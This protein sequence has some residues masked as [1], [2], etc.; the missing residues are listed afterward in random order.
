MSFLSPPFS[1]SRTKTTVI[2]LLLL[3]T[4]LFS[5]LQLSQSEKIA[6]GSG[7][8][9]PKPGSRIGIHFKARNEPLIMETKIPII[10]AGLTPPQTFFLLT[11][12]GLSKACYLDDNTPIGVIT[13]VDASTI[14]ITMTTTLLP[15]NP[16][17]IQVPRDGESAPD[18]VTVFD[19]DQF[20]CYFRID[21]ATTVST[22][23]VLLPYNVVINAPEI[24]D[25]NLYF[26]ALGWKT[27]P[28]TPLF[29]GSPQLD[30][31]YFE[32][33]YTAAIEQ[34]IMIPISLFLI[35]YPTNVPLTAE[36]M[37][38]LYEISKIATS[39]TCGDNVRL[40]YYPPADPTT[41]LGQ[42]YVLTENPT[43]GGTCKLFLP[44]HI[45]TYYAY[46]IGVRIA[47]RSQPPPP[48]FNLTLFI[49]QPQ[50]VMLTTHINTPY[51]IPFGLA[52]IT[53]PMP[54]DLAVLDS[55]PLTTSKPVLPHFVTN[56]WQ[57]QPA[58]GLSK[59]G[60]GMGVYA[61]CPITEPMMSITATSGLPVSDLLRGLSGVYAEFDKLDI[62][63]SVGA[64]EQSG[65]EESATPLHV[66]EEK[67]EFTQSR[68][69]LGSEDSIDVLR[70]HSND[71]DDVDEKTA[72]KHNQHQMHRE[73]HLL[74][75]ATQGTS[76]E[77]P[78]IPTDH[79]LTR[80]PFASSMGNLPGGVLAAS[81]QQFNVQQN[82]QHQQNQQKNQ[83]G[84][85]NQQNQQLFNT[86]DILNFNNV[87][88][89]TIPH[90]QS[91]LQHQQQQQQQQQQSKQQQPST[92]PQIT[93]NTSPPPQNDEQ[94]TIISTLSTPV[95]TTESIFTPLQGGF[96][97]ALLRLIVFSANIRNVFLSYITQPT[98]VTL[99]LLAPVANFTTPTT[100]EYRL[101]DRA[102]TIAIQPAVLLCWVLDQH[103]LQRQPH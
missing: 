78:I 82:Q 102:G 42:F 85:Q 99:N 39:P 14:V 49:T 50:S 40:V 41:G 83:Q 48:T 60:I 96:N 21:P 44:Q 2:V 72:F 19:T 34:N 5:T 58:S 13:E 79:Q 46:T 94:P 28:I 59:A 66:Q 70:F 35:T 51:P 95:T 17:V 20:T 25:F 68:F 30:N 27:D 65:D 52:Q 36:M 77:K 18:T 6:T 15:T 32:F 97:D 62:L 53:P 103:F 100:I 80:L 7:I 88:G 90:L 69:D 61:L 47:T 93:T 101:A 67:N 33:E 73:L 87:N 12:N 89:E 16:V 74:Q 1:T 43:I 29:T 98:F 22:P 38:T 31:S 8:V 92:I 86:L 10:I 63:N 26:K 64:N 11:N 56:G 84:Q 37:Y 71:L 4:L 75:K 57:W 3:S 9:H 23:V 24:T 45:L 76:V 91:I 55:T 81:L 54:I